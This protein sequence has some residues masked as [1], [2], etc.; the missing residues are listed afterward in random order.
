LE[1][2]HCEGLPEREQPHRAEKGDSVT[3]TKLHDI[4]QAW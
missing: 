1:G 3:K 2:V 4:S